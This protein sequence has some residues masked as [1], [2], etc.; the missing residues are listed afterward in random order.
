MGTDVSDFLR[1]RGTVTVVN[2][3]AVL[4]D[5]DGVLHVGDAP[6][7]GAVE[8]VEWL[9]DEGIPFRCVTNTTRRSRRAVAARLHDLGFA[10]P[11]AWCFTPA[12]A[13]VRP[14]R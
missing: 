2:V 13:A 5:L 10:I 9:R 8:A 11:E 1:T 6:V 3:D 14:A 12:L 4:I 7:P